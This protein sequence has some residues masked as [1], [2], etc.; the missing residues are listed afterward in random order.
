MQATEEAIPPETH[1][2]AA[3]RVRAV[4]PSYN[5]GPHVRRVVAALCAQGTDV[6]V[7]DDGSTDGSMEALRELP[8]HVETLPR[9]RGKGHAILAG[10]RAALADPALE[11]VVVLDADGQH[12]PCALPDFVRCYRATRADLV[13]GVRELSGRGVP[14]RSWV[15]NAITAQA[16]R[17]LFGVRLPDTQCGYRLLS[18]AFMEDVVAHVPGGRYDTEMEVLVRA[19]RGPWRVETVRIATLYEAGNPT[20][21]FRKVSDSLAIYARLLRAWWRR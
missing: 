2:S 20:S 3:P 6:L 11:A 9:N 10:L 4:V 19:L 17:L 5:A 16:V 1:D 8:V 14:L 15:G 12:E 21:H 13:M 7:V 18:R